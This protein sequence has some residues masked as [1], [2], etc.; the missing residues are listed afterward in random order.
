M[1]NAPAVTYPVGRSHIKILITWALL[2]LAMGV[3]GFWCYQVDHLGWPQGLGFGLW[4]ITTWLSIHDVL[5]PLR[6]CLCWDGQNWCWKSGGH[7]WVVAVQ[8][9]LDGQNLVLLALS[10]PDHGLIWLWLEREMDALNWDALR[11]AL[12]SQ[13]KPGAV[14]ESH[15]PGGVADPS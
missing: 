10:L 9:Q 1:F 11:R 7:S 8:P 15:P 3:L 5:H 2:L 14:I 4:L 13:G 6:G 12:W